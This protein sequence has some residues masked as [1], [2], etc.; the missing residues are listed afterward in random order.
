MEEA[1]EKLTKRAE[2][3]YLLKEAKYY[4]WVWR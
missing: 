3:R 4:I 2:Q 1:A